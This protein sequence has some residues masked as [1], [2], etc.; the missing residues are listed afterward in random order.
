M[1]VQ[2]ARVETFRTAQLYDGVLSRAFASL[3]DMVH[4]CRHLLA[5]GG[6]F[7]AMKGALPTEELAC[8]SQQYPES[9]VYPLRVPGLQ[10]QRHLVVLQQQQGTRQQ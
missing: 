2:Q 9:T 1:D 7:F 4:G 5:P 8:V 10:E 6:C 3:Q